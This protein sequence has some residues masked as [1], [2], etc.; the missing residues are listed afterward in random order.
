LNKAIKYLKWVRNRFIINRGNIE[1][2]DILDLNLWKQ[3][4]GCQRSE[5]KFII[6][7]HVIKWKLYAEVL[8]NEKV[9]LIEGFGRRKKRRR[10]EVLFNY[11]MKFNYLVRMKERKLY[12]IFT[13]DNLEQLIRRAVK[14]KRTDLYCDEKEEELCSDKFSKNW[15]TRRKKPPDKIVDVKMLSYE[16]TGKKMKKLFKEKG[17]K[18]RR[19]CLNSIKRSSKTILIAEGKR[20]LENVMNNTSENMKM[21]FCSI[22]KDAKIE[23]SV[24]ETLVYEY[25]SLGKE[26]QLV[27]EVVFDVDFLMYEVMFLVTKSE[28]RIRFNRILLTDGEAVSIIGYGWFVIVKINNPSETHNGEGIC[29]RS[30]LVP[31]IEEEYLE[32]G[33]V[34]HHDYGK[35]AENVQ[36]MILTIESSQL[37]EEGLVMIRYTNVMTDKMIC[38]ERFE[39]R[40]ILNNLIL[41]LK[42]M[43]VVTGARSYERL[44]LNLESALYCTY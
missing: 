6:W 31:T 19:Q 37:S 25:R 34:V 44:V 41:M 29:R 15:K 35:L 33:E 13:K 26:I 3:S 4:F 7:K 28:R 39:A 27:R 30:N 8:I 11:I 24:V 17:K 36:R 38:F 23:K 20:N 43:K 12:N 10:I 22:L 5:N 40:K 42:M 16:V 2:A 9:A 1:S 18:R 14:K 21:V 32:A